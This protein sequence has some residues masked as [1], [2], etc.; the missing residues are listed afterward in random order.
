MKIYVVFG[1]SGEYSDRREW[2]VKA[3]KSKEQ[4]EVLVINATQ[5]ANRIFSANGDKYY[6]WDN[7]KDPNKYDP[8]MDMDYT[9]ASYYI[10]EVELEGS[11]G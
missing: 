11:E 10:A 5:E 3:F 4:A 1:T 2:P 8:E 7:E 6:D 9:G